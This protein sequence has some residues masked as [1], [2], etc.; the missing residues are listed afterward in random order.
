METLKV[1]IA[2]DDLSSRILLS[3]FTEI[4][5]DYQVV[6][7]AANG[8]EL[9]QLV[10]EKIP[11]I[12]LADINMPGVNGVEAVKSCKE[13]LPSL[14]IIFTTGYDDFAI[15]A[16]NISA[17]DY[18]V[19]PI[20]RVRL[21]IA[22]E[23]AKKA[24]QFLKKAKLKATANGLN[25]LS[26]KSNNSFVYIAVDEILYIEKEGRKSVVHT[27]DER[28]ETLE[29]LYE[30]EKRVPD[31]F[32]KTHRSY[33]VNLKKIA[34]IEAYGETYLAYFSRPNKVAH[35]SKLKINEVHRL[36]GI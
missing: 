33:L 25:K 35:I 10:K 19:K 7:L 5:E 26:V 34:K 23:K 27:A 6:G 3:N 32:Y 9:V 2:D 11:D 13:I 1:I 17:V 12:V 24:I 30:L 14:Q 36:L 20:E 31:F 15:E 18:I 28:Y 4:L 22:F 29:S 21:F 16:F 8:E